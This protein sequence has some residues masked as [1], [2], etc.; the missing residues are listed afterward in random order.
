MDY[1]FSRRL[2]WLCSEQPDNGFQNGFNLSELYER[3]EETSKEDHSFTEVVEGTG[4][5]SGRK[6]ELEYACADVSNAYELQGFINGFRLCWILQG[7][8]EKPPQK[9][10]EKGGVS[11]MVRSAA[12]LKYDKI[13]AGGN[14]D[15]IV[16]RLRGCEALIDTLCESAEVEKIPEEALSGVSDLLSCITRDLE[17]DIAAAED[18]PQ[19]GPKGDS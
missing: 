8:M 6:R 7:E 10:G 4:L 5:D 15:D 17:A 2:Y 18:Y 9:G 14:L 16:A 3:I 12:P 13:M 11:G 19:G 1:G